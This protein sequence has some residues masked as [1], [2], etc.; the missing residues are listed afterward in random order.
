MLSFIRWLSFYVCFQL[1]LSSAAGSDRA[2]SLTAR[3]KGSGTVNYADIRAR[4]AHGFA[5]KGYEIANVVALLQ[6]ISKATVDL[7]DKISAHC[8]Q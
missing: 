4:V 2:E 1:A 8:S 3:D 5:E 6:D 7:T